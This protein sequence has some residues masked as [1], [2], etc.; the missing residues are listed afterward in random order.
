M[1]NALRQFAKENWKAALT[2][3]V[4][5]LIGGLGSDYASHRAAN[6]EAINKQIEASEKAEHDMSSILQKFADKALG[7][8]TTTPDDLKNLKAS[9]QD[10]FAAAERLRERF[11][12]VTKEVEAFADALVQLQK[13]A[14]GLSGP[15]N[16]KDFV[17]SVSKY[18]ATRM[19]LSKRIAEA[20]TRWR[21]I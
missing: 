13:S 2:G 9:V 10:S 1:F 20:Q 15:A 7:K 14:E 17:Q 6:R 16:G 3:A 11:P 19:D 18:Y 12:D 21:P 8:N 4:G 5:L